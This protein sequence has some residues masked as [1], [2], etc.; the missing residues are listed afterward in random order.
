VSTKSTLILGE[1][2]HFYQKCFE[3]YNLYLEF[4][5][6]VFS[7]DPV[8][9]HDAKTSGGY[10]GIPG[11]IWSEISYFEI[12]LEFADKSD[13]DI[14]NIARLKYKDIKDKYFGSTIW[15]IVGILVFG[16]HDLDDDKRIEI[17]INEYMNR[18]NIESEH[19]RKI[20]ELDM[21]K[22]RR[23]TLTGEK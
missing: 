23:D 5:G 20:R 22:S 13:D 21:I 3:P 6:L 19:A 7:F 17:G 10:P 12:P 16:P 4:G 9:W 15:E 14:I 2:Y 1:D 18:R 11:E 8:K